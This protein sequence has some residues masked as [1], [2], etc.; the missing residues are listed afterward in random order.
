MDRL[1]ALL[2]DDRSPVLPPRIADKKQN[3]V[4]PVG[5]PC[6]QRLQLSLFGDTAWDVAALARIVAA[7]WTSTFRSASKPAP[8][9]AA[10]SAARGP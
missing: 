7:P 6:A 4:W 10:T 9:C 3:G 5:G 1:A 8:R 2:S